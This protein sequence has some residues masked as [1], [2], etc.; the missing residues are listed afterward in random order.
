MEEKEPF[1]E[2]LDMGFI[3]WIRKFGDDKDKDCLRGS[4]FPTQ[5]DRE[6]SARAYKKYTKFLEGK[7]VDEIRKIMY[8]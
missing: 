5:K 4:G 1:L 2:F 6:S 7:S 8:K 3:M